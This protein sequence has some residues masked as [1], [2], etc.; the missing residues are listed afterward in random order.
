GGRRPRRHASP[1]GRGAMIRRRRPIR[2]IAFSFDSFLDVVTNVVGIIIRLILVVWVGARSYSEVQ[3]RLQEATPRPRP[4]RTLAVEPDRDEPLQEEITRHRMELARAQAALLDQLRQLDGLEQ[5]YRAEE[6]AFLALNAR[7]QE[8]E[9]E[10][11]EIE[12]V[13]AEK[14]RAARMSQM[15]LAELEARQ[16][17]L[18]D[19][20]RRLQQLPPLK[21]TLRYRTPISRP[22]QSE[23]VF[24]ECHEGRVTFIPIAALLDEI[25]RTLE[26]KA[27]L[28][29]T[30]WEVTDLTA[31]V[32]AFRLRYSLERQRD[33]LDAVF[34]TGPPDPNA[35]F[36]YGLSRWEVVPITPIRGE[37]L[38]EALAPQSQFRRIAEAI[39]PRQT[40]ITIWV[41]PESF[42][43]FR[44][45]RDFL[46]EREITV[47][48]RPLPPGIPIACSRRGSRSL[49]Q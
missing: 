7:W 27:K 17:K 28:L 23:E 12:R 19:E 33:A 2:E 22:V 20:I 13:A 47:A 43:L 31:P 5:R 29:R 39:D 35:N 21:K 3:V 15:S 44:Q 1:C 18:T 46:Y 8:L 48:G 10:E 45:L 16:R 30:N 25:R 26:E 32:G 38:A 6:G 34:G 37:T 49:G 42:E 4:P 11:T 9:A 41:Y 14:G 36:S 40:V 24:F